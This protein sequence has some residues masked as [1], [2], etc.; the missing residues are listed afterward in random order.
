M[1]TLKS[2]DLIIF[3]GNSITSKLIQFFTNSKYN[4]SALV[5][6]C[7]V[8]KQLYLFETGILKEKEPA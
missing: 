6:K 7:P 3:Q 2:G 5:Y 8:S 1:N 4:H